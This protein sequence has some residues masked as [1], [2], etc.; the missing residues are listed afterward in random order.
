MQICQN[1]QIVVERTLPYVHW[2]LARIERQWRTLSEGAK[3]LLVT[4]NLPEK[5]WEYAV[6]TMI[7]IC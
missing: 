4:P 1:E 2:H 5:F 3:T 7:Y 6:M